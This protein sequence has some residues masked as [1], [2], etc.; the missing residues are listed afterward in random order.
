MKFQNTLR[1]SKKGFMRLGNKWLAALSF[2]I[3]VLVCYTSLQFELFDVNLELN[4]VETII[5]IGT[6]VIGIYIAHTIQR[7]VNKNQ[8]QYSYIEDK[9]DY[10]WTEFI[11][12]SKIFTYGDNV[13]LVTVNKYFKDSIPVIDLVKSIFES[14]E[15]DNK[16]LCNLEKNTDAFEEYL[17][18]LPSTDNVIDFKDKKKEI[19]A[20]IL[21]INKCFKDLLREL[22][23]R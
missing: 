1:K 17:T 23:S 22:N 20:K 12:F 14:F 4:V 8:N 3:G 5:A 16:C 6:A 2:L 13:D 10:L 9:L 7:N 15:F 21:V 19:E 11:K 18:N